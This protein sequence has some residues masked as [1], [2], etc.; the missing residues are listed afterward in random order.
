M[1]PAQTAPY[2]RQNLFTGNG[3]CRFR[4]KRLFWIRD[5]CLCGNGWQCFSID[6][7]AFGICFRKMPGK[8]TVAKFLFLVN[9]FC[10]AKGFLQKE[11]A[12]IVFFRRAPPYGSRSCIS[13]L[14]KRRLKCHCLPLSF[15]SEVCM[16]AVPVG[17][18][19]PAPFAAGFH[20]RIQFQIV[21]FR[22]ICP[23]FPVDPQHRTQGNKSLRQKSTQT[24]LFPT[25][26][27]MTGIVP[28]SY[29]HLCF[30]PNG[31]QRS[32]PVNRIYTR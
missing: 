5:F 30:S 14:E 31:A 3:C 2:R 20:R 18:I 7:D 22:S 24:I 32:A 17:N 21:C 16:F 1:F 13:N 29:D 15:A 27:A 9:D 8:G 19:E 28:L 4:C 12:V 23:N 25:P 6:T 26:Y 11:T 10:R